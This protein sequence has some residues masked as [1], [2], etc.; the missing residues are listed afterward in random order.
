MSILRLLSIPALPALGLSGF[1]IGV[2][3]LRA[4]EEAGRTLA[5][6]LAL[7]GEGLSPRPALSPDVRRAQMDACLRLP[8]DPVSQVFPVAAVGAFLEVCQKRAEAILADTP[9]SGAAFAVLAVGGEAG[10]LDR[11]QKAAPFE[12]WL[13]GHRFA[14]AQRLAGPAA[15]DGAGA[16]AALLIS[17]GRAEDV[18]LACVASLSLREVLS[19]ALALMP[20]ADKRRFLRAA[21]AA[22][23]GAADGL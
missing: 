4:S 1:L 18:A 16:D 19:P 9:S 7:A 20:E 2:S 10:D 22:A 17:L 15:Y 5:E 14:V 23:G 13:A 8:A 12:G 6:I 3:E 11:S 21:E